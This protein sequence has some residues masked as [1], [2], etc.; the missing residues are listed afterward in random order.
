[1]KLTHSFRNEEPGP[2]VRLS[3]VEAKYEY[4]TESIHVAAHVLMAG[5]RF[6]F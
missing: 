1:M 4:Y 3:A 6:N 2:G 5:L